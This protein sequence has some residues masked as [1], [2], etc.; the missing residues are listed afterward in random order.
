MTTV[1]ELITRVGFEVDKQ[2][3]NNADKAVDRLKGNLRTLAAGAVAAGGSLFALAKTTANYG[4][5]VAK[6]ARDVGV[7][8]DAFQEL[9][10]A[11]DLA[12]VS[13]ETLSRGLQ[14]FQR[15]IGNAADGNESALEQFEK[16]GISIKDTSG[17]LRD[18]DHILNDV[19]NA[20]NGIDEP[21]RRAAVAQD[22]FGRSGV[23]L[24]VFLSEGADAINEAREAARDLGIVLTEEQ[25]AN[26]EE[27]NDRLGDVQKAL[28]GVARSVGAELLPVITDLAVK[29]TEFIKENRELIRIRL[30]QFISALTGALSGLFQITKTGFSIFQTFAGLV[31]GVE[32]AVMLLGGA[33]VGLK[34]AQ[35]AKDLFTVGKA[36]AAIAGPKTII[37]GLLLTLG[38][39]IFDWVSNNE[40]A[41]ETLKGI[42][43]SIKGFFQSFWGI[44]KPIIDGFIAGLDLLGNAFTSVKD[45]AIN[46]FQGVIDFINSYV[47]PVI[48]TVTNALGAI[49]GAVKSTASAVSGVGSSVTGAVSGGL[50]RIGGFFGL[51]SSS[52]NTAAGELNA[53]N[54]ASTIES[55]LPSTQQSTSNNVNVDSKVEV[56]VPPGTSDQQAEFIKKAAQQSFKEEYQKELQRVLYDNPITEG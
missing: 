19:A 6:A 31:G 35:V 42:W 50:S 44:A 5:E 28:S 21:A 9:A 46:A 14:R 29:F 20:L 48:N 11:A 45:F 38:K 24:G 3:F 33:F 17:N 39:L 53:A 41:M 4:D 16:L 47:M 55:N 15:E 22:L 8:S 32:N 43:E 52:E 23:R 26:A 13:Q 12:G 56:N 37:I 40:E 25:L 1:R 34:L 2:S 18:T 51:G 54:N 10:Y 7:K 30:D 27:F 49:G 36:V